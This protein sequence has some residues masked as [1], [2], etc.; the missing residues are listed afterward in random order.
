MSA[1]M[2]LTSI[3]WQQT[4]GTV[5]TFSGGSPAACFTEALLPGLGFMIQRRGYQPWGVL[6][7]RQEVYDAG[8]GPVWHARRE[9]YDLLAQ[10]DRLRSW[11]VRLEA[12]SSDWLEEREWRIPRHGGVSLLEFVGDA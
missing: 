4:L 5:I 6:F 12:G 9:Q 10:D 1:S 7:R 11:A 8:G 3:L 2:R